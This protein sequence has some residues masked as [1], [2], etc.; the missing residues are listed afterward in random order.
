MP[1]IVKTTERRFFLSSDNDGYSYVVPVDN[2]EQWYEFTALDESDPRSWDIPYFAVLVEGDFTFSEP[3]VD[4]E[5][6]E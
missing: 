6:V 4:G 1:T 2:R 5:L 3:F